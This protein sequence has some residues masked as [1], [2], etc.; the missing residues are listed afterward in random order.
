MCLSVFRMRAPLFSGIPLFLQ[1]D[2]FVSCVL[3]CLENDGIIMYTG[4][5][6]HVASAMSPLDSVV[7]K[8]SFLDAEI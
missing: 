3:R 4:L 1:D 2:D 6:L 5:D 8:E 7:E